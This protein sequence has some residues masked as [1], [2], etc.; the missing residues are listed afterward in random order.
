MIYKIA[1]ASSD[2]KVIN[3]HYGRTEEF[4][5]IEAD[6]SDRTFWYQE[7]R[8]TAPVCE[9]QEHDDKRLKAAADLLG[10][11]DYVLVSRIG[12]GARY[13]LAENGTWA[14][15]LPGLIEDS[16]QRLFSYIEVQNLFEKEEKG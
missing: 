4:H 12:E 16:V 5:I 13:A 15:E 7:T 9:Q 10:D 2:G 14:F 6:S 1:A 8:K 3:Q 11:C